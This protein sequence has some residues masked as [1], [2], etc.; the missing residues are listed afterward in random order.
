[1]TYRIKTVEKLTGI[2]RNTITAWE[3]RYGLVEP[4]KD[5]SG[6]RA[7]T[8]TDVARLKRVKALVDQGYQIGEVLTM[9]AEPA[10]KPVDDT[11]HLVT[12]LRDN[13]LALD[14]EAAMRLVRQMKQLPLPKQL[15]DVFTPV[16]RQIGDL[17]ESGEA[18]IGQEHFASAFVRDQLL[19][20]LRELDQG[21]RRGSPALCAGF[22]GEQH[23]LGLITVAIRLAHEGHRVTYLGADMPAADLVKLL[24]D[25]PA[26]VVCTSLMIPRPAREILQWAEYVRDHTA[27]HV[28]VAVGGPGV[29]HLAQQSSDRIRF[30]TRFDELVGTLPPQP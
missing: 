25:R 4:I 24:M 22:P 3:R 7:Y 17:W 16:M 28:L 30:F 21:P 5:E 18:N 2:S 23:E 6:Y 1:M 11:E 20:A 8:E 29:T 10:P 26:R 15:D 27:P 13:L 14:R 19:V 9:L 12:S